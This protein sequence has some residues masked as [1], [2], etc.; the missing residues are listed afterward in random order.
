MTSLFIDSD[1]PDQGISE[2]LSAKA[3]RSFQKQ[4][5]AIT[6]TFTAEPIEESLAYWMQE[7]VLPSAITF[8]PYNQLFQQL[9]DP[10]SL[11]SQ[12]Q[13]GINVILLRFEDWQRFQTDAEQGKAAHE[14]IERNVHEL[15]QA[16]QVAAGRSAA[17]HL[18]CVC[19]ASPVVNADANRQ[20]FFARMEDR[21]AEDLAGISGVYLVKSTEVIA[22]YPVSPYYDAY[23]DKVGHV[24]FTPLFFAALGT[25]IARKIHALLSTPY[26]VIV[27]DCDQTLWQGVCGEEGALGVIIDTPRMQ[28]QE[29]LVAQQAA[30]VLLCLCSKNNEQDVFDVFTRHHGMRL[31]REHLVAWRINWQSKSQNLRSLAEE[32]QLSLKSFIFIDDDPLECA[33]VQ[34]ICPEVLTLPLPQDLSRLPHLLRHFWAFDH[35][36]VTSEDK[37]RTALYGQQLQRQE[38][39]KTSSTL[40]EFL[41][42]LGL[43]VE[44]APLEEAQ[45]SRV[46]QLTQRTNQFNCTTIRRTE[47][48]IRQ[49]RQADKDSRGECLVVEVSDRFGGYGLV[50][51][52]L[53]TVRRGEIEVD[54]F[55]L[56]C[57]ALGRGVEHQMLARLGEIAQEQGVSQVLVPFVPTS[58]NTPAREFLEGNEAASRQIHGDRWIFSFATETLVGLVYTPPAEQSE[59]PGRVQSDTSADVAAAENASTSPTRAQTNSIPLLRIATELSTAEQVLQAVAAQRRR[60]PDIQQPVA[61]PRTRI[62]EQLLE[63]WAEV[64][65]LDQV[66]IHDDFLALGGTSLLAVQVISRLRT[67]L[68]VEVPLQSF[69][70]AS[71]IAQLAR[72]ITQLKAGGASVHMPVTRARSRES[73]RV[74]M[75]STLPAQINTSSH[76]Q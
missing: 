48:E 52:I 15:T 5:I 43:H 33:E 38:F 8:T 76:N 70:E 11:L 19:P 26:K 17:P 25:L 16:L 18:V 74:P 3:S 71:T 53:F 32:L 30:G 56:S 72:I 12:N 35:L 23:G 42:G 13:R 54:T 44:I 37:K 20:A 2:D 69:F 4:T 62:E 28:L 66:G 45:L 59:V 1:S 58:Q 9:L 75:F 55:L 6:A 10:A 7:L 14:K 40:K 36:R 50:G 64:L 61:S 51:V 73:Y 31:K 65:K 39:Q 67:I 21:L 68:Q 63:T 24:P 49:F 29:F 22:A 46:A 60:R 34:A 47:S 41:D 57:R 27:V